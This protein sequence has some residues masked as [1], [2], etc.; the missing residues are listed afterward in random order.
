V[1]APAANRRAD[2]GAADLLLADSRLAFGVLNELRYRTL[3]RIFGVSR[4][5]ANLL[6][7]VLMVAG[8]HQAATVAERLIRFPPLPSGSDVAIGGFALREAA[9]GMAGPSA[10]GVS[11]FATLVAIAVFGGLALPS[12]R[13]AARRLRAAEHRFRAWRESQYATARHAMRDYGVASGAGASST[14]LR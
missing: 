6:T 12:A 8:G 10:A 14:M 7:L 4:E 9:A 2:F 13:R 11:P 1:A 3:G 5:Q